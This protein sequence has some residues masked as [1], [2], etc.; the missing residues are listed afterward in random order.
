MGNWTPLPDGVSCT[1]LLLSAS[2]AQITPQG[3]CGEQLVSAQT[4]RAGRMRGADRHHAGPTNWEAPA[5]GTRKRLRK[6]AG[7]K[8][9]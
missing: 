3:G 9:V 8:E 2:R 4:N 7:K 6:K 5:L 1:A